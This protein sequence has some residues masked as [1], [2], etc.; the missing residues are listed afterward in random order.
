MVATNLSLNILTF[1][2]PEEQKEF[3]FVTE[4]KEGSFPLRNY[5]LPA[6]ALEI[7]SVKDLE[8]DIPLYTNFLDEIE[9]ELKLIVSFN[10]SPEFAKHYYNTRIFNFFKKKE[11]IVRSNYIN[12][13][14]VWVKATDKKHPRC[15]YFHKYGL[16][17]QM[18]KV[19]GHPELLVY[20]SGKSRIYNQSIQQLTNVPPEA[21]NKVS[22]NREILKTD[23]LRDDAR[24]ELDKVYPVINADLEKVLDLELPFEKIRNKYANI[25]KYINQFYNSY[26]NKKDF[27]SVI[28]ISEN[29]FHKVNPDDVLY[30]SRKS[31]VLRYKYGIGIVPKKDIWKLKPYKK[32]PHDKL[33]FIFIYHEKSKAAFEKTRS[34]FQGN[35]DFFGIQNFVYI[36]FYNDRANNIVYNDN[37]NFSTLIEERFKEFSPIS[38]ITYFAVYITQYTKEEKDKELKELY[39]KVKEVLLESNISSQVIEEETVFDAGFKW[40]MT[41]I[42]IA[43]LGKLGGI[44]WIL[45]TPFKRELIFGVGAFEN[46]EKGVKY[47]GNTFCF[48]TDGSFKEFDCYSNDEIFLLAGD[49]E[50]SIIDFQKKHRNFRLER[51]IIHFYKTMSERE[52]KPIRKVL[53]K[54]QLQIPIYVLTINKTESQDYLVFDNDY[55]EKMPYSGTIINVGKNEYLLCNNSRYYITDEIEVDGFHLPIKIKLSCSDPEQLDDEVA[56]ELM[57]Q[58]Y[59]FSRIYWKALKQ[60]NLPVT[61]KYPEMV[62]QIAPHFKDGIIPDYGKDNLWFL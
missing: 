61:I 2:H 40:S 41:N 34:Y 1:S 45:E 32:Q 29:G 5:K 46:Q 28:P 27:K 56:Q 30:I 19:T 26:L 14:E 24:E 51:L 9:G 17:V 52:L 4:K 20:H 37:D 48:S 12:D 35:K 38:G 8:K 58:V 7:L 36:P 25:N 13:I 44:P 23:P 33:H 15:T 42:S 43:I 50:M 47:I 59:Q 18:G 16:R 31:N 49:I 11:L 53:E 6:N 3:Q 62:A 55:H 60:Q 21:Y 54:M 22:Y 39:Y 10:D 57:D